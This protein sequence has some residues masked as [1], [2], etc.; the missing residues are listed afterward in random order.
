MA[1]SAERVSGVRGAEAAAEATT[2]KIV[3]T[4][5]A[6]DAASGRAGTRARGMPALRSHL[7]NWEL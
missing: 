5:S 2:A 6:R 4:T 3:A 7:R 1:P